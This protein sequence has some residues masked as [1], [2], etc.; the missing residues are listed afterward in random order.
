L[1]TLHKF[2]IYTEIPQ[3]GPLH[4]R[5]LQELHNFIKSKLTLKNYNSNPKVT[6]LLKNDSFVKYSSLLSYFLNSYYTNLSTY[7][8]FFDNN[9]GNFDFRSINNSINLNNFK[10]L[11][12]L[13]NESDI[14][15]KDNLNLLY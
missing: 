4:Y 2:Q 8:H 9:V 14:L 7:S 13:N 10:D 11:Y 1:L 6:F 15:N 3:I 12:L 5:L